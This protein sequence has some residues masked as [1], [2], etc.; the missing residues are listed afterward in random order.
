MF[1]PELPDCSFSSVVVTKAIGFGS[2][3]SI[4]EAI[5]LAERLG[6]TV[7][8]QDIGLEGVLISVGSIKK[9]IVNKN[10]PYAMRVRTILHE[11]GHYVLHGFIPTS[12]AGYEHFQ[13]QA[14]REANA[15]AWLLMSDS[16]RKLLIEELNDEGPWAL[17]GNVDG[18][19]GSDC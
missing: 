17:W 15:F 12:F 1:L 6:I 5:S 10:L 14:E 18:I 13:Y 8:E 3:N 9:I 7:C 4:E 19:G 11:V 2:V 16:L